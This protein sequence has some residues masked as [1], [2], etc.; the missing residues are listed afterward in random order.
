MHL[1]QP[2]L[3]IPGFHTCDDVQGVYFAFCIF[4][5]LSVQ[6]LRDTHIPIYIVFCLV[7]QPLVRSSLTKSL[8]TLSSSTTPWNNGWSYSAV[9]IFICYKH[10]EVYVCSMHACKVVFVI[11]Q[12]M[13]CL[14]ILLWPKLFPSM[15][16]DGFQ[17]SLH[18]KT[19]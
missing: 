6:G 12:F 1:L 9:S 14:S 5:I 10:I 2:C 13:G 7:R 19:R 4:T 17:N 15:A 18:W 16:Y 3:N 8:S 11:H